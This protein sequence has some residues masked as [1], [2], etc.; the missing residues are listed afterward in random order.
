[1]PP[2]KQPCRYCSVPFALRGL[3]QHERACK[4]AQARARRTP[5]HGHAADLE[6]I[7]HYNVTPR[8]QDKVWSGVNSGCSLMSLVFILWIGAHVLLTCTDIVSETVLTRFDDKIESLVEK[9]Y[10]LVMDVRKR[11]KMKAFMEEQEQQNADE[12]ATEYRWTSKDKRKQ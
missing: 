1:M 7:E 9:G 4:L 12:E 11:H 8:L 2:L 3:F 5:M 10:G 6:A